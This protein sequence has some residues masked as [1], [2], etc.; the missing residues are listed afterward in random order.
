MSLLIKR[1]NS[2]PVLTC[3]QME[4]LSAKKAKQ[5]RELAANVYKDLEELESLIEEQSKMSMPHAFSNI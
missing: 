3:A 4:E 1:E 5:Q 2:V